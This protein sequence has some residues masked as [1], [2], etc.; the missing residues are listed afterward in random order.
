MMPLNEV[1]SQ[2]DLLRLTQDTGLTAAEIASQYDKA[3]AQA[4]ADSA[5]K[6]AVNRRQRR[7]Q[8]Q[9]IKKAIKATRFTEANRPINERFAEMTTEQQSEIY[10]RILERVKQENDKFERMKEQENGERTD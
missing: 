7:K 6:K 9:Q 5:P 10:L 1:L 8:E 3:I 2:E 4:K